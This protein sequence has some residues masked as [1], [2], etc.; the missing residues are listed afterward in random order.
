VDAW[1]G[2]WRAAVAGRDPHRAVDLLRPVAV[3]RN[4]YVCARFL[5]NIEPAEHVYHAVDVGHYLARAARMA[6]TD[7]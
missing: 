2:R 4:A 1:A 5:A 6:V 3:L 7:A